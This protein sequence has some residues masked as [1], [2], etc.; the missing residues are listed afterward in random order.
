M[1]AHTVVDYIDAQGAVFAQYDSGLDHADAPDLA[2]LRRHGAAL[3]FLRR[4]RLVRRSALEACSSR[5]SFHGADRAFLAQMALRG[6]LIQLKEPLVQM[7]EHGARYT[8]RAWTRRRAGCGTT[9]A[10]RGKLAA[11]AR[12]HRA[13]WRPSSRSG[14]RRRSWRCR[15]RCWRAGGW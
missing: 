8:R 1:L 5:M 13:Y 2:A 12:F 15:G 11:D 14:W 9:A 10:A 6:R 3:A 4:F 7:R